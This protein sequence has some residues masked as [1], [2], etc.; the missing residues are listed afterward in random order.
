MIRWLI[1]F[2]L[3]IFIFADSFNDYLKLIQTKNLGPLGNH[4]QGEIEILTKE[5]L[6]KKA[7][8]DTEKRL[9]KK[10]VVS[11]LAEEW[12]RIGIIAEDS[13][14]YWIRDAVIFPSGIYGTYDRILWKSCVEGPP[15][16]AIAP[17]IHKKILVNLNYRHATRSWEIELPR[18]IRNPNETLLKACERELYEETGYSLKNHCLLGTIAVDSGILSSLVPIVYCHA[19][20]PTERHS[21]FSEAIADNIALTL[22]ELECAL[23]QGVWEV[24]TPDRTVQA[25]VRDPFLAYA[26]LQIKLRHLL[27]NSLDE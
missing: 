24:S 23:L 12:T 9:L 16:I 7:Q 1:V 15:G 13:Y 4:K 19:E 6:I 27:S 25:H 26:L 8:T 18:G 3:P 2:L 5:P 17:I 21:D 14:L 10:G 11:E 20:K 22:E